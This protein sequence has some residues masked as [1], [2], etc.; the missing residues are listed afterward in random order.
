MA[1]VLLAGESWISSTTEY[2][3]YDSF[4]S[5]KLEIG[6]VHFLE[7]MRRQGHDV[8]HL[9][10]H[11]VPEKFPWTREELDNYDVII[12][13]DIGLNS[14][15]LPNEV[16][17]GGNP[18]A[19]R[20]TILKEWVL[21]GGS[22]MMAGGYLSFGGFEGKA[23]YHESPIEDIL[24]VKILPYDD[25][26]EA[27]EGVRMVEKCSNLITKNLGEFPV[28]LGYQKIQPKKD[29]RVLIEVES[30]P[31]L[32]VGNAGSGRTLAYAT[33]IAPHWASQDFMEWKNYGTFFS[34]CVNWLTG[35]L[36]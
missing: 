15:V 26:I 9:L 20:L 24:P 33:D 31:L 13:S 12:L 18:V 36:G 8:H 14:F 30:S 29:S 34:R 35:V 2:K 17:V 4:S 25:R 5:T 32:V 23:H 1:K 7:E 11:D 22:L 6:C 28:I 3:G 16:F 27:P 19:N 21:D 10:A